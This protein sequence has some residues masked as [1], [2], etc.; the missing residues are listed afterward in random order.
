MSDEQEYH[1]LVESI[2]AGLLV[3]GIVIG[4]M[5][6]LRARDP[7]L[8]CRQE[9]L[10]EGGVRIGRNVGCFKTLPDGKT[11]IVKVGNW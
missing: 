3:V 8:V 2:L 9:G 10:D 5:L 7:S 11:Y 6:L 4:V 1:A